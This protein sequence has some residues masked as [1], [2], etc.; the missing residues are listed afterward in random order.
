MNDPLGTYLHD[1]LAGAAFA[2]ELLKDLREH[3]PQDELAG[4]AASLSSEIEADHRVLQQLA[5]AVESHPAGMKEAVAWLA[6]KASR[7]KLR[8]NGHGSFGT[9]ESLEALS[10]GILG[11]AALWD[12]LAVAEVADTRLRGPDYTALARRAQQQH[13]Q[14]EDRRLAL[15]Q[16]VFAPH[17]AETKKR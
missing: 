6:E 4:F 1:H 8:R 13:G 5:E 3:H 7:L 2:L 12:A 10:L 16:S 14:V 11:K 15:A 17:M 9:F